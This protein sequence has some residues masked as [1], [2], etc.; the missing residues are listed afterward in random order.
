[1]YMPV[2]RNLQKENGPNLEIEDLKEE[3]CELYRMCN[4][5]KYSDEESDIKK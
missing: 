4:I 1:M 2:T 5:N 3:M